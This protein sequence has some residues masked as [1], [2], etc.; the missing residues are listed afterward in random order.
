MDDKPGWRKIA[1]SVVGRFVSCV[2]ISY[3]GFKIGG[4]HGGVA[5]VAAWGVLFAK[6]IMDFFIWYYQT[7][8]QAPIKKYNGNYYEFANTQIRVF[9]VAKKLWCVDKD[10]LKVIGQKPNVMLESLYTATEYDQISGTT[11]NGFSEDGIEKLLSKSTHFEALRMLHW[12]QREVKMP[13][14]RKIE[15]AR[16]LANKKA[17]DALK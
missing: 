15:V 9:V 10:V 17:V 7:A 14:Y 13:H 5:S 2:I 6:P 12:F 11:L 8:S 1:G 16:E 3:L 4:V